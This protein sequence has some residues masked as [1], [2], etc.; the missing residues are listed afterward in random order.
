MSWWDDGESKIKHATGVIPFVPDAFEFQF[1]N[2]D[3]TDWVPV[4]PGT[5]QFQNEWCTPLTE[6][7]LDA[8]GVD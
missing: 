4:D 2:F 1:L 7:Q 6:A 8:L 5:V 3:G